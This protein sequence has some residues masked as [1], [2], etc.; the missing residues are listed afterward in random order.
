MASPPLDPVASY[1]RRLAPYGRETFEEALGVFAVM[2][3]NLTANLLI[4]AISFVV[5]LVVS[6][7]AF[8]VAGRMLSGVNAKFTDAFF[9]ALFGM[10][11]GLGIDTALNYI[12]VAEVT[13]LVVIAWNIV[14]LLA[15]F[16]AWMVLVQHFFD[17]LFLRG[18]AIVAIAFL[19]ILIIDVTLLLGLPLL[20]TTL[21]WPI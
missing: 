17:C 6:I 9:V 11:V 7:I 18:L 8:Y 5:E 3:F 19:I 4:D 20:F 15:I 12:P 2:Q 14:G 21:G 10:L 16:I 1:F 13:E